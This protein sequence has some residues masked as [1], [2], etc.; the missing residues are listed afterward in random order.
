M[1][2]D[3]KFKEEAR[4]KMKLGV[5]KLADAVKATLGPMGRNVV[6]R[7]ERDGKPNMTKDGVKVAKSINLSDKWED[8]GAQLVKEAAS[9]TSDSA[10]DGTT[11]ATLLAQVIINEGMKALNEGFNPIEIKRGMDKTVEIVIDSL[12]SQTQIVTPE[13]L[14]SIATISANNDD[15][16]GLLVAGAL[17]KVGQDGVVSIQKSKTTKTYATFVEGIKLDKGYISQAFVNNTVKMWVD[18]ENALILIYDR[19]ISTFKD[20]EGVLKISMSQ[21]KPLLVIA[22]DVDAEALATL[23]TNKVQ[24]GMK[25]AA[26][27]LNA[28]INY[29]EDIAVI[30]GATV[31]SEQSGH[32]LSEITLKQLGKADKITIDALSTNIIGG[33]GEKKEISARISQVKAYMDGLDNKAEEEKIKKYRLAK[34]VNGVG[35]LH[36]GAPT[37]AEQEEK[38]D[39]TDDAVCA[40]KA[41]MAEGVLPGGGTAYL[42]ALTKLPLS[43][44]NKGE[45]VGLN[46]IAK[47][48]CAP[49]QQMCINAGLDADTIVAEVQAQEILT[50]GFNVKESKFTDMFEAGIIDPTKVTRV[51]LE[52]AASVGAMFLTT[53][54]VI[55]DTVREK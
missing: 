51:A 24:G 8:T 34:L 2:T 35:I 29:L 4:N 44:E 37:D 28:H 27:R 21:K 47:A 13:R 33:K 10:G 17:S 46:I 22:E 48:L 55:V 42:R 11:T 1:L 53:E 36:I 23:I 43:Y 41:A 39:R 16:M 9:K 40:T 31:I 14:V 25:V 3:L 20:I 5:D 49:L 12:R 32:V 38:I 54:V 18:F 30:T 7:N 50:W 6:I 26:I 19:K 15:E 52:H 45:N